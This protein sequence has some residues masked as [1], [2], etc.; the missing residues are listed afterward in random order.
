L[1]L[2]HKANIQLPV[3]D[4]PNGHAYDPFDVTKPEDLVDGYPIKAAEFWGRVCLIPALKLFLKKCAQ[5]KRRKIL[6]CALLA[7]LLSI[8]VLGPPWFIL[9]AGGTVDIKVSILDACYSLYLFCLGVICVPRVERHSEFVWHLTTLTSLPVVLLL[10]STIT[11]DHQ[12]P[13]TSPLW[14]SRAVLLLYIVLALA[15]MNTPLGPPLHYPL[16][17]IYPEDTVDSESVMSTDTENVTGV[18]GWSPVSFFHTFL[19]SFRLLPL[20][21]ALFF[22][23]RKG[24]LARRPCGRP[25]NR[26]LACHAD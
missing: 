12:T 8:Q 6:I 1:N 22:L 16:S 5:M 18:V 11:P 7:T 26:R 25:R 4:E 14:S 3:N 2:L 10:F 24:G 13:A 15:T 17:A 23:R 21:Y 9:Y 20:E 19:T